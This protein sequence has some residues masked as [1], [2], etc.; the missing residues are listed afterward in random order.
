M[1]SNASTSLALH[2]TVLSESPS[3]LA[4]APAAISTLTAISLKF[5]FYT[6]ISVFRNASLIPLFF[7]VP[8]T[9]HI[10]SVASHCLPRSWISGSDSLASTTPAKTTPVLPQE[11]SSSGASAQDPGGI[12]HLPP[13]R[14][15]QVRDPLLLAL[16]ASFP[17]SDLS[18][19]ILS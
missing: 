3:P 10:F 14:L 4:W 6:A 9:L 2:L 5:I 1:I 12:S 7:S 16:A 8:L 19:N 15:L 11:G 17:L 18:S 13:T